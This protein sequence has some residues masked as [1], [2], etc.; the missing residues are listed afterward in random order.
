MFN[1][2]KTKK[3]SKERGDPSPGMEYKQSTN[4]KASQV[5][6]DATAPPSLTPNFINVPKVKRFHAVS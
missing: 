4:T 1:N 2:P 3:M 5:G 6:K